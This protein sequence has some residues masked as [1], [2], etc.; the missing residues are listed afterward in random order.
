MHY[1]NAII[2]HTDIDPD[3]L[4]CKP[5]PER[6]ALMWSFLG[7]KG[8][9]PGHGQAAGEDYQWNQSDCNPLHPYRAI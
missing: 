4:V 9:F 6:G 3:Y 8:G 7:N 1:E 2:G 5:V